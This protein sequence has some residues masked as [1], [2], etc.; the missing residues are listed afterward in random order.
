MNDHAAE[1]LDPKQPALIVT[2]GLTPRKYLPLQ[3]DLS[4]NPF[5]Y[6]PVRI[7]SD[8]VAWVSFPLASPEGR[9]R[10]EFQAEAVLLDQP[11]TGQPTQSY[12]P[13]DT[14]P[15]NGS[16]SASGVASQVTL[17]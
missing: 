7:A 8:G 16:G 12:G 1:I 17:P 15:S 3:R 2:Y 5:L 6:Y 10:V 11:F 9:A 13:Y 14:G 4:S